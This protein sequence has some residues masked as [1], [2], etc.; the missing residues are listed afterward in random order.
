MNY[1]FLN[2]LYGISAKVLN[3]GKNVRKF[4]EKNS[5]NQ[6]E[7]KLKIKRKE[8]IKMKCMKVVFKDGER[9]KVAKGIVEFEKDFVKVIDKDNKTIY[10]NNANVV[11]MKDI[12]SN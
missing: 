12:A 8:V 4:N 9:D 5:L 11:F 10:I 3:S 7:Q 1:L 2:K 6:F